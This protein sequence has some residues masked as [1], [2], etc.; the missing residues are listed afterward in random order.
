MFSFLFMLALCS[1]W[2]HTLDLSSVPLRVTTKNYLF[3]GPS[4]YHPGSRIVKLQVLLT[5]SLNQR[6]NHLTHCTLFV[7]P[8]WISSPNKIVINLSSL[9]LQTYVRQGKF[10]VRL[11]FCCS[12]EFGL[13]PNSSWLLSPV[14][15][16]VHPKFF[17]FL[18]SYPKIAWAPASIP[19]LSHWL[20][21][22]YRANPIQ[23]LSTQYIFKLGPPP[24]YS[25]FP[26]CMQ[27]WIP[28]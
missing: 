6:F 2:P 21:I 10:Q 18:W 17:W 9:L 4:L 7:N 13:L 3:A 11:D 26:P 27:V 25:E 23:L 15:G 22:I 14:P 8:L 16:L 19:Y 28:G 5:H 1:E 20:V 12:L 24:F